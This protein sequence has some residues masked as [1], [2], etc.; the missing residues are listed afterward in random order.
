MSRALSMSADAIMLDSMASISIFGGNTKNQRGVTNHSKSCP[1]PVSTSP[2]TTTITT[3]QQ[4]AVA[5]EL[6]E[7]L[8]VD[9]SVDFVTLVATLGTSGLYRVHPAWKELMMRV[10]IR[11]LRLFDDTA[12]SV[13][14]QAAFLLLPAIIKRL[15]RGRKAVPWLKTV[16]ASNA[17]SKAIIEEAQSLA[18]S[19]KSPSRRH[20]ESGFQINIRNRSE[21]L[22]R[23][24]QLKAL[25]RMITEDGQDGHRGNHP[26]PSQ[27]QTILRAL[28]PDSDPNETWD[29]P[30]ELPD[31]SGVPTFTND[32][33]R[34]LLEGLPKD[35]AKG[36]SGWSYG[37]IRSIFLC[38]EGGEDGVTALRKM[39]SDM[40]KGDTNTYRPL[41]IG[42]PF[43]RI[44]GKLVT[45]LVQK[46]CEEKLSPIQLGCGVSGGSDKLG[47]IAQLALGESPETCVVSLDIANAFGNIS[48]KDVF[49]NLD[50][51]FK[52]LR[53]LF[54]WAYGKPVTL[55]NSKGV[56]VFKATEGLMQGDSL[57]SMFFCLAFQP[58]LQKIQDALNHMHTLPADR[59]INGYYGQLM[60]FIDDVN[61][62]VHCNKVDL[63]IQAA[64]NA[65]REHG[66]PL[67]TQKTIIIKGSH[68]TV[69]YSGAK[70]TCSTAKI[71]GIPVGHS[72]DGRK[73]ILDK[74]K[75]RVQRELDA[76]RKANVI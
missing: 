43:Y 63:A 28:H 56:E 16:A 58:V 75:G 7:A 36:V 29:I 67:N 22:F 51:P 18:S 11:L 1:G 17:P 30:I 24:G 45:K 31:I 13:E 54:I 20:R 8:P 10:S 34:E 74:T 38:E 50:G 46:E 25:L 62:I 6:P 21:E 32:T 33:I 39:L 60:A 41:A 61:L 70:P 68:P 49:S 57:S 48:R 65:L 44:L 15:S 12:R 73:A 3:S 26:T 52:W 69:N 53:S 27:H 5:D 71:V 72:A 35:K 37:A 42:D 64:E 2:P 55:F 76:L 47:M 19:S 40:V 9:V 23:D 66:L 14:A 4:P 59:G